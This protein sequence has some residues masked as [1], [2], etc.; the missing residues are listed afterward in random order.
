MYKKLNDSI[1]K[2]KCVINKKN[3][4][5]RINTQSMNNPYY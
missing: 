3:K 2:I 4:F 5:K 1:Y